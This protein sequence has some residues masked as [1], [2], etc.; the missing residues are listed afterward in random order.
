MTIEQIE[1]SF[2]FKVTD[3]KSGGVLA[4]DFKG[5]RKCLY[6]ADT[7]FIGYVKDTEKD[8]DFEIT[9]FIFPHKWVV[10]GFPHKPIEHK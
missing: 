2:R 3:K 7:E 5:F 4:T 8:L 9:Q 6:L 10:L 1:E